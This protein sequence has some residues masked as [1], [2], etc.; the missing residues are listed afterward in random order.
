MKNNTTSWKSQK[1]LESEMQERIKELE[2]ENKK[3]KEEE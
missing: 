2:K 1:Q 3:L